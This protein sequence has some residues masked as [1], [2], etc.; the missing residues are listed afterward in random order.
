MAP[1]KHAKQHAF[2]VIFVENVLGK[3][4]TVIVA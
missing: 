3:T 1:E 4:I 2:A